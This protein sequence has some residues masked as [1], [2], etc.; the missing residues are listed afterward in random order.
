MDQLIKNQTLSIGSAF[1]SRRWLR[2]PFEA[3]VGDAVLGKLGCGRRRMCFLDSPAR[4]LTMHMAHV[5]SM[6]MPRRP[7][8]S[9]GPA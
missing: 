9:E 8:G 1:P 4:V 3:S 6:A 5:T 7:R 2:R